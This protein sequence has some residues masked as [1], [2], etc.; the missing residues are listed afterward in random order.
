MFMY[1]RGTNVMENK[2]TILNYI[3]SSVVITD[4]NGKI[5]FVNEPFMK[6]FEYNNADRS[7]WIGL[8][9]VS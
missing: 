8:D 6:V 1:F 7:N 9:P 3:L 5:V 4:D 2:L